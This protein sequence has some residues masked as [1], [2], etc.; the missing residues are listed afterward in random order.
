[1]ALEVIDYF[2]KLNPNHKDTDFIFLNGNLNLLS[3]Q[4]LHRTLKRILRNINYPDPEGVSIHSLRHT[5]GSLLYKQGVDLKTI[6][7]LLG[8]KS[9]KTTEQIYIGITQ[10][11]KIDAVN[12]L[13]SAIDKND[14]NNK[15]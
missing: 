9:V 13:N 14:E 3:Q 15:S 1:M 12:V 7:V 8:H 10:E 2:D 5:F 4:G 6:S 11:Q